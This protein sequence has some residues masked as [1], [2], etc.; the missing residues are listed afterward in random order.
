MTSNDLF[1]AFRHSAFDDRYIGRGIDLCFAVYV[2]NGF[3]M[4][5]SAIVKLCSSTMILYVPSKV[6]F[7]SSS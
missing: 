2:F 3:D 5:I 4:G 1:D 6:K 7:G